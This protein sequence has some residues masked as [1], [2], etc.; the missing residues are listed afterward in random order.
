MSVLSDV[1]QHKFQDL[2][3]RAPAYVCVYWCVTGFNLLKTSSSFLCLSSSLS[4]CV[5]SSSYFFLTRKLSSAPIL[6][7]C[8]RWQCF[9]VTEKFPL[10]AML[11]CPIQSLSI[12]NTAVFFMQIKTNSHTYELSRYFNDFS[13]KQQYIERA[14]NLQRTWKV[15]F[16]DWLSENCKRT[17]TAQNRKRKQNTWNQ[18]LMRSTSTVWFSTKLCSFQRW[19]EFSGKMG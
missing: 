12:T 15:W 3:V 18:S 1:F 14:W 4:F 5:S 2:R 6:V 7:L 8:T 16:C 13:N 9:F 11:I 10:L 17:W 19:S